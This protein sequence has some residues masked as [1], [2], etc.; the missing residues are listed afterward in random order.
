[1]IFKVFLKFH[2]ALKKTIISCVMGFIANHI[3]SLKCIH[4]LHENTVHRKQSRNDNAV[5]V[6]I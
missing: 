1:M 3:S 2:N 6:V 4:N 5:I